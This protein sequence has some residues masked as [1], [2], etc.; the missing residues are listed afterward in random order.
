MSEA[1]R[2]IANDLYENFKELVTDDFVMQN[3]IGLVT[4]IMKVV[5]KYDGIKGS[6]KKEVVLLLI[7]KIIEDLPNG[8]AK[9]VLNTTKPM[10]PSVIDTI[11]SVDRR[12]IT[13]KA[14]KCW[15]RIKDNMCC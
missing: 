11:I 15:D 3:V 2:T 7:D 5:D 6:E 4:D 1:V 12:K 8:T 9:D 10:L 13:I 14:R